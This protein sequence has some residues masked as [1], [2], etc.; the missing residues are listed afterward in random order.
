MQS[1]VR[2]LVVDDYAPWRRL[3]CSLLE[4]R[5]DLQVVGEVTD[6]L[7]AV[8]KT[9]ELQPDLILLDIGLPTLNGIEAARRIRSLAPKSKILFLS[10]N[11]SA[12]IARGA[13]ST[14]GFGFVIKSDA[15]IELLPAVDAVIQ[16]LQ[17]VS[18]RLTG[19]IFPAV[20]NT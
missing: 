10:E 3:V 16:G 5:P 4:E 8:Q 14:G 19:Q 1:P 18:A 2:I 11:Y 17:F 6:G 13:L 12:D 15:G 20:R 9:L 7:D